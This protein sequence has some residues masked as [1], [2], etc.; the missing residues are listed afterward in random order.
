MHPAPLVEPARTRDL[1]GA[2]RLIFQNLETHECHRRVTNALHLIHTGELN[3]EG[4]LVLRE[5]SD[6]LGATVCVAIPGGG[7]LIWPPGCVEGPHRVIWEDRLVQEACRWLTQHGVKIAQALLAPEEHVLAAP[8]ER[9]GFRCITTLWY[10]SHDLN[11]P[12]QHLNTPV[13]LRFQ[14]Y[15]PQTQALFHKTL[16]DTYVGTL[17]CPEVNGVRTIE[18]VIAGHR[19]QG[20]Y[21][22]EHWWLAWW[23]DRPAGVLIITEILESNDWE[24]AYMGVAAFARNQG[25]GREILLK[26]LFE[27]RAAEVAR[28]TLSVDAR[29]LSAWKLY[30]GVGFEPTDRR[31]VYLAVWRTPANGE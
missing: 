30:R 27:A 23:G 5:G 8:L 24:V 26:G 25:F 19:S 16:A 12:V 14:T 11:V 31:A 10:M 1:P 20:R 13:R 18:E 15:G 6:L 7:G 22:P 21:N 28:V 9:N 2:F 3:R 17:D 29:N 4:I